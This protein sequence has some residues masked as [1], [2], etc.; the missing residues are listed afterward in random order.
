MAVKNSK[1]NLELNDIPE[2]KEDKK[3]E[4]KTNNKTEKYC[5]KCGM[6][7]ASTSK[8]CFECGH[9]EFYDTLE[10]YKDIKNSKYCKKCK[11]KVDDKTKFC[12][13]CGSQEFAKTKEEL[14]AYFINA[15]TS[16]WEE[17]INKALK[18]VEALENTK[19]ELTAQNKEL[20][21]N[22]KKVIATYEKQ[23]EKASNKPKVE[24]IDYDAEK[25]KLVSM[26]NEQKELKEFK[27]LELE[28]AEENFA[29]TNEKDKKQYET[30]ANDVDEL[31]KQNLELNKQIQNLKS[32]IAKN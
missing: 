5:K 23:Y 17:K 29:K 8:F 9:D 18:K 24:K 27:L 7:N 13:N 30:L 25:A 28:E 3:E 6:K 21:S 32:E 12:P 22:L 11:N 15:K 16:E 19:K 14:D 26:I 10:E 2:I 20:N 1:F 4:K 31:K